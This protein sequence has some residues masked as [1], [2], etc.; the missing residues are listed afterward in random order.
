MICDYE[1]KSADAATIAWLIEF[2]AGP[3]NGNL[4][5]GPWSPLSNA[6]FLWWECAFEDWTKV[7]QHARMVTTETEELYSL[8][9]LQ[10]PVAS[11]SGLYSGHP[12]LEQ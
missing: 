4:F 11:S 10:G 7:W 1:E 2:M 3:Q 6:M 5:H 12:D 8:L 9:R